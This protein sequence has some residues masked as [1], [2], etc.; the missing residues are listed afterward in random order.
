MNSIP[1]RGVCLV[2]AAPSGA[3]KTAIT[4]ALLAQEH[5]LM[6]SVSATTRAPRPGERDGVH[7]HFRDQAAFDAMVAEGALL[8]W[9]QVFGRCYGTPRAPVEQALA[10]GRDMVFD[11]D[12]QGYR[13]LRAALPGDVTGV[14]VLPPSLPALEGR[15]RARGGDD[16][17][18][19]ARRM[20]KARDEI[21]HWGE[22]EHVIV[23]DDFEQAVAAVRAVLHAARLATAR[24]PG[25]AAFVAGLVRPE[26]GG[27]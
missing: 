23:N 2:I 9:A 25:L 21:G 8:E 27:G 10:G 17:A 22:F 6:V 19:I 4:R 16:A 26:S 14:F 11:I 3:G 24:Q 13:Q 15:L 12:W 18:E 5:E 7:Y 1:R 20:A